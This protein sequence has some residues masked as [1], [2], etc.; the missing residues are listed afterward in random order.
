ML[1][2]TRIKK[3]KE[4]LLEYKHVDVH[5]LSSLLSVSV[6]TVR[7][8]LEK[9]EN[10]QFLKK[11]HGGAVLI[12][13]ESLSLST[14]AIEDPYKN[15]KEQIADIAVRLIDDEDIIF[16]GNGYTCQMI[17]RRLKNKRELTVI[18]NNL[19]SVIELSTSPAIRVVMPGGDLSIK[20]NKLNLKGRY[21]INN[22]KSMFFRKA[23]ITVSGVSL[24]HGYTVD[25]EDEADLY[26]YIAGNSD[27]VILVADLSKF[28]HRG[29]V[30]I[31]PPDLFKKVITNVQIPDEYKTYYYTKQISLFTGFDGL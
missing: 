12:E 26:K 9:L 21:S 30:K 1:A 15:E 2:E 31:G 4:V 25:D 13:P 11:T 20:G 3:I 17:A 5:T 14:G 22:I 8:D 16:L 29:F 7:R 27:E 19:N 28:D 24:E 18:T 6:N 10:E 23:F